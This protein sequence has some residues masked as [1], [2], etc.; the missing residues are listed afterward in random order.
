[1][2]KTEVQTARNSENGGKKGG[3]ELENNE[4]E[5]EVGGGRG[6]Y[7]S[8]KAKMIRHHPRKNVYNE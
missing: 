4:D 1:L 5:V 2:E 7:E 3:N 6:I 8:K